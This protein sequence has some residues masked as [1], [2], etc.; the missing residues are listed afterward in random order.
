M[1][2]TPN[3]DQPFMCLDMTYISVLLKD[4]Y[5]LDSRTKVKVNISIAIRI[6]LCLKPKVKLMFNIQINFFLLFYSCIRKLMVTKF[7]GLWVVHTIYWL[8]FHEPKNKESYNKW[9]QRTKIDKNSHSEDLKSKINTNFFLLTHLQGI[10]R[11][12]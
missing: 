5:G 12:R 10:Y 7:H 2:A 8:M 4:G 6:I 3:V 9:W 1:C 11:F